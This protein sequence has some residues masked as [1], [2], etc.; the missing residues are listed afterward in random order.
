MAYLIRSNLLYISIREPD[1]ADYRVN[2]F[3]LRLCMKSIACTPSRL[4]SLLQ[5]LVEDRKS[6]QNHDRFPEVHAGDN[7]RNIPEAL[8]FLR[9]RPSYH[10]R[11]VEEDGLG[12]CKE[13]SVLLDNDAQGAIMLATS[14]P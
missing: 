9:V 2:T 14:V 5:V 13:I 1:E 8:T 6:L 7:L 3:N 11:K 4:F 10:L 12:P